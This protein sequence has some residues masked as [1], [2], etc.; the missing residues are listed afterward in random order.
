MG[1]PSSGAENHFPVAYRAPQSSARFFMLLSAHCDCDAQAPG[2][3]NTTNTKTSPTERQYS[4]TLPLLTAVLTRHT[5]EIGPFTTQMS[6][7][8]KIARTKDR[9]MQPHARVKTG[10]APLSPGE[11]TRTPNTRKRISRMLNEDE[12]ALPHSEHPPLAVADP[13]ANLR[14]HTPTP[15]GMYDTTR[16]LTLD[17]IQGSAHTTNTAPYTRAKPDNNTPKKTKRSKNTRS[18]QLGPECSSNDAGDGPTETTQTQTRKQRTG[19]KGRQQQPSTVRGDEFFKPLLGRWA[20]IRQTAH[21]AMQT[22]GH[23]LW[24]EKPPD[25]NWHDLTGNLMCINMQGW[26]KQTERSSLW[27]LFARSKTMIVALI[28]HRQRNEKNVEFELTDQWTGV[29]IK[30]DAR[31]AH[32]KPRS[33]AVGGIT[34]AMHPILARYA[35]QHKQQFDDPR[36]WGRWTNMTLRGKEKIVVIAAYGPTG[37]STNTEIA[38]NS[39]WAFQ[40][41]QLTAVPQ[42]ERQKNARYQFMYDLGACIKK[43]KTA[44]YNVILTGDMNVAINKKFS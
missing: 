39:M 3:V 24:Y 10:T 29:G 13:H 36:N 34:I 20:K 44:G 12:T 21:L 30:K 4:R 26:G 9:L 32:V 18:T 11:N 16:P 43:A 19:T 37:H 23:D 31:F 1:K 8:S 7:R 33:S 2:T 27:Q 22:T 41:S 40:T 5:R 35:E 15:T 25:V 14:T 42:V 28:D 38:D 6:H 17:D